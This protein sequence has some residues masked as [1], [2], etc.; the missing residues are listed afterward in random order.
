[1]G[2]R[3][4]GEGK[5]PY[6]GTREEQA[7]IDYIKTNSVP[8]KHRLYNEVL[9]AP[10]KTMIES[11]LRRY[12]IH[13]GN[14]DITEVEANALSHLIEKMIGFDK[15]KPT[16]TGQTPK[17]FSYCQTII[18]NF[19]K[20]WSKKTFNERISNLPFEDFHE[21][22]ENNRDYT[23]EIDSVDDHDL[24][25]RLINKIIE[26]IRF[27]I[28]TDKTLKKNEIIVGEAI[29]NVL[30]NWHRLFLEETEVGIYNKKISNNFAKNKILLFLKEQTNL[31]TK[32]IRSSMKQY[33]ELYFLQ[34]NEFLSD[35]Y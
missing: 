15:S 14:Y 24:K 7:L 16:K 18:R 21:E 3:K 27:R 30:F 9:R 32:E 12:P 35:E 2:K 29:I 31:S 28:D 6:F 22:V 34:K 11:I 4:K 13:I 33:K 19:Y 17:A 8:E 10:F 5:E 25:E 20:D 1:M 23:Y 26:K